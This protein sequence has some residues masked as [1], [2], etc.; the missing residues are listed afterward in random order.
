MTEQ[1]IRSLFLP[2]YSD[3]Q[4]SE[5]IFKEGQLFAH[6]TSLLNLKAILENDEVWFSNPLFMND[7]EEVRFGMIEGTK[8][9]VA[10]AELREAAGTDARHELIK[11]SFDV[12][13]NKFAEGH[14][15][16]TYVF[17]LSLPAGV[18]GDCGSQKQCQVSASET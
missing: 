11:S 9:F 6:Y 14:V 13:F 4:Q 12:W 2:L 3:L 1:D 8:Q 10:S 17:C 15:F 18:Q 16:D 7:M 5:K